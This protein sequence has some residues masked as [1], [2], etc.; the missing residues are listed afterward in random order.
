MMKADLYRIT[1]SK[2]FYIFWIVN[3]IL[4]LINIAAL[5]IFCLIGIVG[6]MRTIF[7]K[8]REKEKA[9]QK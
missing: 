4:Y 7:K 3:A 6:T 8:Q 1:K 2:S 9:S 5:Y